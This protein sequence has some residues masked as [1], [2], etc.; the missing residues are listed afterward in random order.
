MPDHTITI[1]PDSGVYRA[2]VEG[3]PTATGACPT[4]A[5]ACLLGKIQ[6]H[7]WVTP[8]PTLTPSETDANSPE[9]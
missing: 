8:E 7:G 6:E 3:G 4:A 5:L 1:A 2:T 9:S